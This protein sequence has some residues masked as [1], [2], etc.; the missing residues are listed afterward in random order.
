MRCVW[1]GYNELMYVKGKTQC[2]THNKED[3]IFII[4]TTVEGSCLNL[5]R[6]PPWQFSGKEFACQRRRHGFNP[7]SGKIPHTIEQLS[8]STTTIELVF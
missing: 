2:R 4:L 6:G 7:W 5:L 8:L 3:N 1:Q